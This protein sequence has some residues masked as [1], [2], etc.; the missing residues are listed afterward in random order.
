MWINRNKDTGLCQHG[1]VC[2]CEECDG[3]VKK[4]RARLAAMEKH[5]NKADF[6][7][8]V[9]QNEPVM[10]GHWLAKAREI[11]KGEY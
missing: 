1:W 9:E 5:L 10:C 8:W 2:N 7:R 3:E 4:T 11:L 6:P